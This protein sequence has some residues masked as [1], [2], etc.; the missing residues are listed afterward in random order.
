[1]RDVR[2]LAREQCANF[3]MA[4][5]RPDR[6]R[7]EGGAP[8]GPEALDLVAVAGVGDHAVARGAEHAPLGLEYRG[9]SAV[10]TVEV[11]DQQDLHRAETPYA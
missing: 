7:C 5:P 6:G 3:P 2:R 4:V 11:V 10:L 1:M 9:L 8:P